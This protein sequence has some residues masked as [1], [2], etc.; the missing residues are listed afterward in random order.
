M[1]KLYF[2]KIFKYKT[3]LDSARGMRVERCAP[4]ARFRIRTIILHLI[5]NPN[6]FFRVCIVYELKNNFFS[7]LEI[8]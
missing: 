4:R 3:R 1:Y 6:F 2:C 8:A 7:S 5:K